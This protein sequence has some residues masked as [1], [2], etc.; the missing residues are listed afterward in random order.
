MRIHVRN[1]DSAFPMILIT[2]SRSCSPRNLGKSS[3]SSSA[4]L[5]RGHYRR[6]VH[7]E[8]GSHRSKRKPETAVFI[9][10]FFQ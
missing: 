6:R 2:K 1:G 4:V 8:R 9:S 5:F 7:E 10:R 3:V